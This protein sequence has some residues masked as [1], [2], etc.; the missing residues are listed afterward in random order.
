VS[1]E[2]DVLRLSLESEPAAWLDRL[3]T[4][5]VLALVESESALET[6]S[7]SQSAVVNPQLRGGYRQGALFARGI[8]R[9]LVQLLGTARCSEASGSRGNPSEA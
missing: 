1:R 2:D 8:W 9:S 5:R 3:V 7:V 6:R 4:D